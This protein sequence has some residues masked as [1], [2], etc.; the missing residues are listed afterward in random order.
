MLP[1]QI[2]QG[3]WLLSHRRLVVVVVPVPVPALVIAAAAESAW[4]KMM[5]WIKEMRTV[6]HLSLYLQEEQHCKRQKRVQEC[7]SRAWPA[8]LPL[9]AA[10][11]PSWVTTMQLLTRKISSLV[12]FFLLWVVRQQCKMIKECL[13]FIGA[14]CQVT[15]EQCYF[16]CIVFKVKRTVLVL[17]LH[18]PLFRLQVWQWQKQMK[19]CK[20]Q[21]NFTQ[22]NLK[23]E[24]VMNYLWQSFH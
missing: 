19:R 3:C 11:P 13:L 21:H 2:C 9:L 12:L 18:H 14:Q 1:P 6:T 15:W 17:V 7:Q 4:K 20:K 23:Q 10:A 24:Q 8:L 16:Y 22:K 5:H